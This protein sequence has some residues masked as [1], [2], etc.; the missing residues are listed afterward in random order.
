MYSKMIY[1]LIVS[2]QFTS[3]IYKRVIIFIKI[4]VFTANKKFLTKNL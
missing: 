4:K 1:R 3:I 2:K